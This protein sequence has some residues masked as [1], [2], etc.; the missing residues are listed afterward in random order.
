MRPAEGQRAGHR[1]GIN[2]VGAGNL[3]APFRQDTSTEPLDKGRAIVKSRFARLGF[4]LFLE[5][6]M[7]RCGHVYIDMLIM[8]TFKTFSQ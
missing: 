3:P 4:A 2:H 8:K 6:N 5:S 1:L 7:S